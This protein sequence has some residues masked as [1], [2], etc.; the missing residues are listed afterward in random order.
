VRRIVGQGLCLVLAGIGIGLVVSA[1]RA[2][3]ARN[4]LL[5]ASA[6]DPVTLG[7]VAVIFLAVGALTPTCRPMRLTVS[8]LVALR[9]Q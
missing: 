3:G 2:R 4:L 9:S 7:T 5:E 6:A 8:P 1:F